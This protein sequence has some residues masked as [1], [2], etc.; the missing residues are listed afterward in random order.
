MDKENM[1]KEHLQVNDS[2]QISIKRKANLEKLLG[3]CTISKKAQEIKDEIR[4]EEDD[5]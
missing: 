4:E 1:K 2:V 5:L 3:C